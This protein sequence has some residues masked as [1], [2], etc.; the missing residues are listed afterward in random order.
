MRRATFERRVNMTKKRTRRTSVMSVI[1]FVVYTILMIVYNSSL[2]S[3][4]AKYPE[5]VIY[6][7]VSTARYAFE[8]LLQIHMTKYYSYDY[9]IKSCK[10][11]WTY[12]VTSMAFS[13]WGMAHV[14]SPRYHQLT[15]EH[16]TED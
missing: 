3:T 13:Y 12:T 16:L 1:I 2:W 10:L 5:I 14:F 4:Y 7:I 9:G 6:M 11:L 8:F 15:K